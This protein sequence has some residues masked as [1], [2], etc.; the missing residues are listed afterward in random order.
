MGEGVSG[1]IEGGLF[2]SLLLASIHAPESHRVAFAVL[3][4]RDEAM[5]ADRSLFLHDLA[6][7]ALDLLQFFRDVIDP[8]IEDW[9][10]DPVRLGEGEASREGV[11]GILALEYNV[12]GSIRLE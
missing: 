5:R 2:F 8:Q 3:E 7:V 11:F 1:E 10:V 6:A 4:M 12:F 9:N